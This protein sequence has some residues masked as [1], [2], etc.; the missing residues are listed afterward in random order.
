MDLKPNRILGIMAVMLFVIT[1]SSQAQ[2]T[3]I[4]SDAQGNV[5]IETDDAAALSRSMIESTLAGIG[6]MMAEMR[7]KSPSEAGQSEQRD[8]N[9]NVRVEF[10]KD[11]NVQ[12]KT[13]S[14]GR[15]EIDGETGTFEI[16]GADA[17]AIAESVIKNGLQSVGMML[18]LMS[19]RSERIG[20]L[21]ATERQRIAE[22][23]QGL[24]WPPDQINENLLRLD[25]AGTSVA[26][27]RRAAEAAQS[28]AAAA[29]AAAESALRRLGLRQTESHHL[30]DA[31]KG[32]TPNAGS[33][34]SSHLD[35]YPPQTCQSA[36]VVEII[37]KV[38][39]TAHDAV[40]A[41][42]ACQVLIRD[43]HIVS[44]GVAIRA[45]GAAH[46]TVVD[47][48]VAGDRGTVEL[49]GASQAS[50]AGSTLHGPAPNTSGRA[51]LEDRGGNQFKSGS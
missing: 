34:D 21:S 39:E 3:R 5:V 22:T 27:A 12:L 43:S 2:R 31:A 33:F 18:R 32:S 25:A 7:G 15:I 29:A 8:A 26:E 24:G 9:S 23:W 50:V 51:R 47:S 11:G 44:G 41:S 37:G 48:L 28:A 14:G 16:Y 20:T 42:G 38:I 4:R 46:V 17:H 45:S 6:R 10:D 40:V 35:A 13:N 49:S 1:A 19:G 30:K 36:M